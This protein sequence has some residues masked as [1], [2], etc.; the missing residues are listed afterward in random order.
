GRHTLT[1]KAWDIHNNSSEKTIE[2]V[3]SDN[4]TPELTQMRAVPNPFQYSSEIHLEHNLFNER[5]KFTVRIFDISG[6]LVRTLGPFDK[7]S[8]GY[9]VPPIVWDGK[10][11]SGNMVDKGLFIYSVLVVSKNGLVN[12]AG[13]KIIKSE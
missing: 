9:T 7:Q 10:D 8:D 2:F 11:D 12:K 13:G 6:R 3:V 4:I 1:V 5:M